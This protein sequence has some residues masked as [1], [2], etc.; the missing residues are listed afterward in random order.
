MMFHFLVHK[1]K[2]AS[3]HAISRYG[4]SN[5]KVKKNVPMKVFVVS[6]A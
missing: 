5:K 3:V 4:R 6:S 1:L 2:K